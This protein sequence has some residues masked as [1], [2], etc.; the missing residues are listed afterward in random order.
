M[1]VASPPKPVSL[2]AAH[3]LSDADAALR[4]ADPSAFPVPQR[5]LKRVITQ[6]LGL[7]GL[8]LNV[9]H[10]K[11]W[12]LSVSRAQ[13]LLEPDELGLSVFDGLPD[14]VVLIARPEDEELERLNLTE[15]RLRYW[16]LLFHARVHLELDECF[17]DG[18]LTEALIRRHINELGQVAF[19][20]VAEVLYREKY[21]PPDDPRSMLFIEFA[22][23]YLELLHF[24]PQ[25][26]SCYFP[27]IG[28]SPEVVAI[29]QNYLAVETLLDETYVE[30]A[31][32][33]PLSAVGDRSE[34]ELPWWKA[35]RTGVARPAVYHRLVDRAHR[36]SADGNNARAAR[37]WL[38]AAQ[39][40]PDLLSGDAVLGARREIQTLTKRLQ[41]AI[42][43]DDDTARDWLEA[44]SALLGAARPGFWNPDARLLYDLQKVA[45]DH[46][47][48]V[49]VVDSWG[50]LKSFGRRPLRRKLPYQRE[51]L[52]SRHLRTAIRRLTSSRL[53][54]EHRQQL[55]ELL[56]HAA[57][58]ADEQLRNRLRPLLSQAVDDVQLEPA[59]IPEQVARRK[60]VEEWLD[61]IAERG[62]LTLG[63]LR[64]AISRNPLKLRDLTNEDLWTGGPL[65]L[66]DKR[67]ATLLDG[68][69]QRGEFYL[70]WLQRLSSA[71]FGTPVGRFLTLFLI[72]PFGG[73][74]VVLEGIDHAWKAI[75]KLSDS[76]PL[77]HLHT[78]E[79]LFALGLFF[80][81]LIHS[82][83][84]RKATTWFL[85]T[86]YRVLK[87]VLFDLPARIIRLPAFRGFLRSTPIVMLRRHLLFPLF[88]T[89]VVWLL[90]PSTS[91]SEQ[92]RVTFFLV[93][94]ASTLAALNSRLGRSVE[95]ATAEWFE[96]TWYTVRVRIFV[97]L[98]EGIMDF[99][100]RV[101]E[102]IER[103]LYAVDEWLRFKT[104]ETNFTLGVK[105]V[106]GLVWA[107]VAYLVR[108]GVN[109]LIEPQINPIKHFPVVT[110]SH[111]IILPMQPY[112]AGV[113]KQTSLT[114][115]AAETLS[116]AIIFGIP[117]I[118]GFLVWELKENWRLY[119]ANRS[120]VLKPVPVGSHGETVVRLLRPG[121]HSGMIPK[122]YAKL[123]RACRRH[124]TTGR[125]AGLARSHENLHHAE[126]AFRHFIE[127][128]LIE[129]LVQAR[130]VDAGDLSVGQIQL[131]VDSIRWDLE[132]ARHPDEPVRF[133][134]AE[135]SGFLIG[136]VEAS[137]WLDDL[138]RERRNACDRAL[139]GLYAM[140]GV[141]LVREHIVS[142]LHHRFHAYDIAGPG[143]LVWPDPSFEA[144]VVYPFTD[145]RTLSPR[146]ARAAGLYLLP[147]IETD[148]IYFSR[149]GV[150]WI[151]WV[152]AW[153]PEAVTP[154]GVGEPASIPSV[155]PRPA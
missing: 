79:S 81:G 33:D 96:W 91:L 12:L 71:V 51:V 152:A 135:Q 60:V 148:D 25:W 120:P 31:P 104:G 112:L 3:R 32:R 94:F 110:V 8:G 42:D 73:A 16:R 92:Y 49:F 27:A 11:S 22:A 149:T 57:D 40:A 127:R 4:A 108:F 84:L 100:K 155:L 30:G 62:F 5:L 78:Q 93:L 86:F 118:F 87:G 15:L 29:L 20:E 38:Q 154:A 37:L 50:W 146:P 139:A 67:C 99:F 134:F 61:V 140:S 133:C 83:A 6:D 70:R 119:A 98:F 129:L 35:E 26:L 111:K 141:E 34:T 65:L 24:S 150:R 48:E 74:F 102:W 143:L 10:R 153:S 115:V 103:V 145:G 137:G 17:A 75:A 53:T 105:A 88:V 21:L 130:I 23:V 39:A 47:R 128:E 77:W 59:N 72:L 147:R 126:V 69:Y 80:L 19:D 56:H 76:V 2:E 54:G 95:A 142:A 52:M 41:A 63:Y 106:L 109:L 66:L 114:T 18:R 43:F 124:D 101:T 44:L 117:G 122:T 132:S 28:H 123:R 64:D 131:T 58:A 1:S 97:A 55:S 13:Q 36:A 125:V 9:P 116:G 136:G 90:L 151:D 144:E 68:V 46:E 14:R 113:L 45:L 85:S 121:F 89:A 7:T 82:Q 107:V 138:S